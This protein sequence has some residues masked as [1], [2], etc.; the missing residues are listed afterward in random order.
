MQRSILALIRTLVL[1]LEAKDIY[2]FNHSRMVSAYSLSIGQRL[3]LKDRELENLE[4]AS[5]LHDIGKIA[6]RED[7]LHKRGALSAVEWEHVKRHPVASERILC[8]VEELAEILPIVR[9]HH[10]HYDGSG[11][12]DGLAG[13]AIPLGARVIAVADAYDAMTSVRPHRGAMLVPDAIEELRKEAGK[14]FDPIVVEAFLRCVPVGPKAVGK[15]AVVDDD[16]T[17]LDVFRRSL[18]REGHSVVVF[19]NPRE[20][21]ERLQARD[22]D[23]LI[24]DIRMPELSG[25][26]VLRLIRQFEAELPVIV[27]TGF[28]DL[29][30]DLDLVN[31]RVASLIQKPVHP[32][33]LR[34]EV[35][36]LLAHRD[37]F[38]GLGMPSPSPLSASVACMAQVASSES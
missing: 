17:V 38:F 13:E 26:E 15:I 23:V 29:A 1:T 31:S 14:Q 28:S 10:E 24:L 4:V 3:K 33:I 11:Y 30:N 22:F 27:C 37:R 25:V 8:F 7:I 6:V 36:R 2:T 34:A 19:S 35:A 12:P 21:V 5:I 16:K 32:D 20:A 9:H 18:E